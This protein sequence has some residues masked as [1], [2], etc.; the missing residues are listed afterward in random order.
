MGKVVQYS[1][2]D[3]SIVLSGTT[4]VVHEVVK[5]LLVRGMVFY[6]VFVFVSS[7]GANLCI[8]LSRP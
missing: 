8:F 4:E 1:S 3:N 6:S 7:L 5:I 2:I